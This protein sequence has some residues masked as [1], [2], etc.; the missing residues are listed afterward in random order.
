M[1]QLIQDAG[2]NYLWN[3]T[4]SAHAIPL[5]VE[6][7]FFKAANADVWLNPSFYSTRQA[8]FAADPRFGKF[9]AAKEGSVYNH[10]KQQNTGI[11]NP[12]WESGILHPDDVLADLIKIF[13][14]EQ[15]PNHEFVYY[16]K[17]N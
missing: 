16:E 11:G 12:I 13:H 2:G 15:M 6:R 7:V 3:G 14:P 4:T 5:N 10:T 1:A 8:L 9:R 17:L